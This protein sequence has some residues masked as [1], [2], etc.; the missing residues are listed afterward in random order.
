MKSISITINLDDVLI[1]YFI[2][3]NVKSNLCYSHYAKKKRQDTL[4][5]WFQEIHFS[6]SSVFRTSQYGI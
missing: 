5:I 3:K 1:F 6:W 2:N 4:Q